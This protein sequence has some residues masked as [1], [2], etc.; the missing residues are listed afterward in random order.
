MVLRLKILFN[1]LFGGKCLLRSLKNTL[2]MF[3]FTFLEKGE[4]N[5]MIFLFLFLLVSV[6]AFLPG[7]FEYLKFYLKPLSFKASLYNF[8]A[9][10]N[11]FSFDD[12]FGQTFFN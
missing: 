4:L 11:T 3:V 10:L 8:A 5:H 6:S 2:P 7:V 9:S 12:F 1:L